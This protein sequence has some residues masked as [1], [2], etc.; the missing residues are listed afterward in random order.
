MNFR[1]ENFDSPHENV[2]FSHYYAKNILVFL[3]LGVSPHEY[4]EKF[5]ASIRSSGNV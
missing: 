4:A 1:H 5:S 3:F 2:D